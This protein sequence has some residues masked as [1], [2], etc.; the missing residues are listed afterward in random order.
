[1]IG[2]I[3]EIAGEGRYLHCWRGFMEVKENSHVIGRIPLDDMAGLIVNAYGVTYSNQLLVRLAQLGV[4]VVLCGNQHRPE[5][6]IWPCE[7]NH[8]QSARLDAQI[9]AKRPLRKRLWQQ[10]VRAKLTA[11]AATLEHFG[12]PNAPLSSLVSKVR[13]GDSGNLEGVGARRYWP[14]LFGKNFRR[15]RSQGEI[16]AMLNYGYTVLRATV[17]RHL[18]STGLH[19]GI[20]LAH[21]NAGN[22]MRLVDDLVEPFRPLADARVRLLVDQGC[23]TMDA[24]VRH[25]LARVATSPVRDDATGGPLSNAIE[26]SCQSLVHVFNGQRRDLR[27]PV[28]DSTTIAA[29]LET[30]DVSQRAEED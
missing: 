24:S 30:D 29:G 6:I 10:L 17:A 14:L 13:S 27:L 7:S 11:Q 5:A 26:R 2:R 9:A 20:G 15:D 16:N 4:P 3:V 19:P 1:M 12:R 8:I 21:T 25:T 22:A 28:I 18:V 23:E